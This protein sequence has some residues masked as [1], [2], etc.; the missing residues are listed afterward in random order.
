M[1][2]TRAI[3]RHL[4]LRAGD[5]IISDERGNGKGQFGGFCGQA[6]SS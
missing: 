5:V 2:Y 3:G 1:Q 4:T 6:D